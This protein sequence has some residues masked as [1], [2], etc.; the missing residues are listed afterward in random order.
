V[1]SV[2]HIASGQTDVVDRAQ[3][4]RVMAVLSAVLLVEECCARRAS[5]PL[6]SGAISRCEPCGPVV[7][8]PSHV[9]RTASAATYAI[10]AAAF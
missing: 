10:A 5:D 3:H 2:F 9:P 1:A 8:G 4:R 6:G 7:Q